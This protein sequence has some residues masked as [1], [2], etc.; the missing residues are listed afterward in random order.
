MTRDWSFG[1]V[2]NFFSLLHTIQTSSEVHP[3]SYPVGTKGSFPGDE[4][5]HSPPASA[6]V[7]KI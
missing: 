4:A 1:R 3:T 2:K 5:D 6:K 7:K